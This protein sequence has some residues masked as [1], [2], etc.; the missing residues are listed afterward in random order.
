MDFIM[1]TDRCV[2]YG[3]IHLHAD[4]IRLPHPHAHHTAHI[5]IFNTRRWLL[6]SNAWRKRE[7]E[8]KS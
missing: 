8:R 4:R 5:H 2:F 3:F 7:R 1:D 6:S